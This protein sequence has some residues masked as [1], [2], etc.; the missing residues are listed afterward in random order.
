M[1]IRF[2]PTPSRPLSMKMN[3]VS[4]SC[5]AYSASAS[6]NSQPTATTTS[7]LSAA[8]MQVRGKHGSVVLAFNQR[9]FNLARIHELLQPVV[10]R[11]VERAI[12]RRAR[13]HDRDLQRRF[14][15]CADA[16][17][18]QSARPRA[19]MKTV[20]SWDSS[21]FYFDCGFAAI[22]PFPARFESSD[23]AR[24]PF[25]PPSLPLRYKDFPRSCTGRAR[26]FRC[27]FPPDTV[28]PIPFPPRA[29][30]SFS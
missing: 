3:F 8:E 17:G 14:C 11:I 9:A 7:L 30:A 24:L 13:Q 22:M 26:S 6:Q 19:A 2:S 10:C 25:P 27:A 15:K 20:S 28:P 21:S 16:T 5:G 12:A 29:R 23:R 18:S 1:L 4:G